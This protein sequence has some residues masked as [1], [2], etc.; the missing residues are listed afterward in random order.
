V[1]IEQ[2]KKSRKNKNKKEREMMSQRKKD[3]RRPK[4]SIDWLWEKVK[5]K[6]HTDSRHTELPRERSVEIEYGT[7][8]KKRNSQVMKT[9]DYFLHNLRYTS[10]IHTN[11]GDS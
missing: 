10:C 11:L 7:N 4:K 9:W 5:K 6:R 1:E 2:S 8:I 3:E